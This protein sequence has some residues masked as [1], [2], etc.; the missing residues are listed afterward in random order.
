M[1]GAIGGW[2]LV[3]YMTIDKRLAEQGAE[4]ALLKQR[5]A[6]VERVAVDLRRE[7][8][9]QSVEIRGSLAKIVDQISD[10]RTLVASQS[11]K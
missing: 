1:L 6:A 3:G 9:E 2:A 4:N 5:T 11:R 10:L 8:K 7:N